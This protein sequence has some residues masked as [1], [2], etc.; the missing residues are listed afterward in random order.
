MITEIEKE[1][2][3]SNNFKKA[4]IIPQLNKPSKSSSIIS[5]EKKHSK[6][7]NNKH[8]DETHKMLINIIK[9]TEE[10][11]KNRQTNI[12]Y[13]KSL[14]IT[15][16]A[17]NPDQVD[18][19][20]RNIL[21]RACLQ[22]K[23]PIIQDLEQ[24]LTP[25]YVQRLDKFG[26]TALI[27]ACKLPL[28][29]HNYERSE[30]LKILIKAG[31]NIQSME[32]INGWTAL[33]W[34]CYNGDIISTKTLINNGANFF[35]PSKRGFFPIDLA[36]K[37]SHIDLAKYLISILIKYL[38]K[39]QNYELLSED[40]GDNEYRRNNST[41]GKNEEKKIDLS[42]LP[43]ISQTIYLRLYTEHCLYWCSYYNYNINIINKF[44]LQFYAHPAFPIH[45]LNYKTALHAS[46]IQGSKIQFKEI[47]NRY[48]NKKIIRENLYGKSKKI[49]LIIWIVV[50]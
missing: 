6:E 24:Q 47:L 44:L 4:L 17:V 2:D 49:F 20:K 30:I 12:N 19:E 42:E 5:S 7:N 14:G 43:K 48:N 32:P 46:C 45:C 38:E 31:A 28:K 21:H 1:S 41:K 10:K 23:L 3:Y 40:F 16:E 11:Y 25:Q 35:L 15:A 26:N 13:T 18:E 50:H 22:I 33:H 27:L 8:I 9:S 29:G 34:C 37:K 39:I 36:A